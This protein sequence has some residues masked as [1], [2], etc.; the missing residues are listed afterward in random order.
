MHKGF[1]DYLCLAHCE[2]RVQ[3]ATAGLA[4]LCDSS[5]DYGSNCGFVSVYRHKTAS[6]CDLHCSASRDRT[7]LA[8]IEGELVGDG[9][10]ST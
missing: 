9:M 10:V 3:A 1:H 5:C 4:V 7:S 6:G 2:H 8:V